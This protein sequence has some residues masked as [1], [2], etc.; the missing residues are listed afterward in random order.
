MRSIRA[1]PLTISWQEQQQQQ[2]KSDDEQLKNCF[3]HAHPIEFEKNSLHNPFT[4]ACKTPKSFFPYDQFS[5][6]ADLNRKHHKIM[7][8]NSKNNNINQ[9]SDPN[10]IARPHNNKNN[11]RSTKDAISNL[12]HQYELF[13]VNNQTLIQGVKGVANVGITFSMREDSEFFIELCNTIVNVFDLYNE[14]L[15]TKHQQ[16][17]IEIQ[18]D[19]RFGPLYRINQLLKLIQHLSMI[20]E[21]YV[22]RSS[23]HSHLKWPIIL[24]IEVTKAILKMFAVFR[25]RRHTQTPIHVHHTLMPT[26]GDLHMER[27][28]LLRMELT[29][30]AP[31]MPLYNKDDDRNE[32]ADAINK[33]QHGTRGGVVGSRTKRRVPNLSQTMLAKKMAQSTMLKPYDGHSS[34]W[35]VIMG[36]LLNAVRP[37]L[38]VLALIKFGS[39]SWQPWAVSLLIDLCGQYLLRTMDDRDRSKCVEAETQRRFSYQNYLFKSPMFDLLMKPLIEWVCRVLNKIPLIGTLIANILEYTVSIQNYYFYTELQ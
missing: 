32:E 1:G 15:L 21:M 13:F 34:Q 27:A 30:T 12:I 7:Y 38:Y 26:D 17:N 29:D 16:M 14:H 35:R 37:V 22:T 9:A 31:A 8:N 18:R 25:I 2:S 19:N 39:K 6:L 20:I 24:I 36:E 23:A 11:N 28:E 4:K 3:S 33:E 10:T 5:V